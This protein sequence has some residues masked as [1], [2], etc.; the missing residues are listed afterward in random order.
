MNIH[1][2]YNIMF[3]LGGFRKKR[4]K[5]FKKILKPQN[6]TKILDVGGTMSNWNYLSVKPQITLLNKDIKLNRNDYPVNVRFKQG[7]A[8]DLSFKDKEYDIAY[9]NSVIEHVCTW[10][11]QR[12]FADEIRRVGKHIWVQTP[13][14][15]FFFEP[16]L[17]TPFIH[18]LP[19]NWQEIIIRNFT[20]WG[21]VTRPSRKLIKEFLKETRL[22]TYKKMEVLFP[23]CRIIVTRWL[24]MP[25]SYI[26]Y[27]I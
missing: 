20:V 8:L 11:N 12:K 18:W 9:S 23:D 21:W 2:I 13:A 7:D 1:T 25:K 27:R 16:H 26:A 14:K 17:L 4:M 10:E 5:L 15:I 24:G 19:L 22:L 3:K 6:S